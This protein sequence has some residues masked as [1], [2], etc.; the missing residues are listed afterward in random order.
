MTNFS[1][2]PG[3]QLSI[4][5]TIYE[6]QPYRYLPDDEEDVWAVEGQEAI[7]YTLRSRE[8]NTLWALK[9]FK[10]SYR[11]DYIERSSQELQ[12]YKHMLGF[13]VCHRTCLTPGAY[14]SLIQQYPDLEYAVLMPWLAWKTWASIIRLRDSQEYTREQALSLATVTA[15]VLAEL[16]K[17]NEAHTDISSVNVLCSPDFRRVELLDIE[18]LYIPDA[19]VRRISYGSVGYQQRRPGRH[20]LSVSEGDRFAGAILLVEMLTWWH[21]KLRSLTPPNATA[22]FHADELQYK[23]GQRWQTV[24]DVLWSINAELLKLFDQAWAASDLARCPTLRQW[25]ECLDRIAV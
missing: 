14:S 3:M 13:Y 18:G 2:Y 17:Q 16:E 20:G 4:D 8:N 11:G 25:S 7:I 23:R 6:F 15:Q 24:R 21:P 10:P 5:S 12:R 9:V 1:P 22:L 19:P